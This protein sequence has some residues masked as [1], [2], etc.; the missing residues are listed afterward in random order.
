MKK[1]MGSF[2]ID[3]FSEDIQ[4]IQ[5]CEEF[6]SG[7]MP[8]YVFGRNEYANSIAKIIDIDGFIDDFCEEKEHL[9]KPVIKTPSVPKQALVV[10]AVIGRPF[11]AG[12]RLRDHKIRYLDYFAFQKYASQKIMTIKFWEDFQY[13]LPNFIH[14]YESIYSLLVDKISRHTLESI[15]KF[16]MSQNLR[17]MQGFEDTQYRQ[18]FEDFLFLNK[19]GEC[20]V[21]VGAF[22]GYTSLEFIKRFPGYSA[23]H[24]FEPDL[25]NMKSVM[26]NLSSYRDVTF[27]PYGLSDKP[28]VLRFSSSGSCSMVSDEGSEKIHVKRLDDLIDEPIS[29]LKMDIEG[30]E[31]PAIRGAANLIKKFKPKLAISVYHRKHDI[32]EI[33]ELIL[34][35]DADY[36]LF[37]R[38]Y[39]E[40]VD[41]TVMFF[42]PR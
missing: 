22:D 24:L 29:F 3:E 33:P 14:R 8:R 2:L 4:A 9:G 13:D 39:T 11:T 40:G 7:N 25:I 17:Y 36:K 23:I 15:L 20:F 5:F 28:A 10:S 37:L 16:R 41:E 21:D 6:L 31:I 12:K 18:Y 38:H 34:S 1:N 27:Y 32:F 35:I 19:A 42:V 30:A 26:K